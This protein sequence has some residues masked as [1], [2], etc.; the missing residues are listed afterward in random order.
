MNFSG[1][2]ERGW[3]LAILTAAVAP[4]VALMTFIYLSKRI[5]L[6]PLPLIIRMFILGAI[7]VFPLMFIQ[8]AF[9]SE[10]LFQSPFMKSVF[11]A[12]LLE[13]FFKWFFLLFVAYRHSDFDHH[14]DGIIYGVSISL[15]FATLENILYLFANGIE[16]ALLRALFPVSSHAL[17]GLLMGYYMGKA[18]FSPTTRRW[19]LA[20]AFIIPFVLHSLYD[21]FVVTSIWLY[22]IIPF[23]IILWCIGVRKIKLANN[24]HDPVLSSNSD[25]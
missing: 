13:E 21:Y 24:H 14:Y 2:K 17:F 20:L 23:M 3:V 25:R 9:E 18:K 8:Y 1:K 7:L 16:I 5:E 22:L 19:S 10:G 4:A 11:L 12:G 6:E 15:G